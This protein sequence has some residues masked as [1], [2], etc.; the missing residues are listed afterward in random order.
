ME[1]R[2]VSI[3]VPERRDTVIDATRGGLP[4]VLVANE[5]LLSFPYSEVFCWHLEIIFGAVDLVD[6]GMPSPAESALL[7]ELTDE[8]EAAILATRTERDAINALFLARSTW[9]GT[10]E[11]A[12]YVHDPEI[13]NDL[14]QA[15][16]PSREWIRGWRYHMKED[17][18]WE[19][20]GQVFKLFAPERLHS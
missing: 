14:L 4:E 2:E 3:E 11:L 10:C 5:A 7:F 19:E 8:I 12:F 17:V 20:A 16:L 9:N 18:G 13:V 6:N 1:D 15:L